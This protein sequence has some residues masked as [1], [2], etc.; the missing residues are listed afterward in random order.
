MTP[1]KGKE[2]GIEEKK[3][4]WFPEIELE[5]RCITSKGH[6]GGIIYYEGT[7]LYPGCGGGYMAPLRI[8]LTVLHNNSNK[9]NF[10][11]YILF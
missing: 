8:K 7:T 10:M 6:H 2:V 3:N 5:G 11:V 4:Q 9:M 1:G